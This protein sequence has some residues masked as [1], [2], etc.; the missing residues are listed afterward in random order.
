MGIWSMH[1]L[2]MDS[3]RLGGHLNHQPWAVLLSLLIAVTAATVALRLAQHFGTSGGSQRRWQVVAALALGL[4]VA[5]MHYTAMAG[6]QVQV[7]TAEMSGPRQLAQTQSQA[8]L[9]LGVALVSSLLMLAALWTLF[10]DRRL[11]RQRDATREA[12]IRQQE[13]EARVLERTEEL[14][15]SNAEL[16]RFAYVASHDLQAPL[17]T[18][19]SFAELLDRRYT[20][21]L[22]DR[23]RTYL[24]HIL[25]SG[26]HM[27][28]LID[29]LL[30]YSRLQSERRPMMPVD[31]AQLVPRVIDRLRGDLDAVEADISWGDL[32]TVMGDSLPLEQVFSNLIGNAIKYQRPGTRPQV[33]VWAEPDP[34]GWR[35]GVRDNGI[36][37]DEPYFERIFEVFQRLHSSSEYEGTGIGLALCRKIVEHHGGRLWVDSTPGQG[38]TFW[39]TLS[40]VPVSATMLEPA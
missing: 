33:R 27:K 3:M 37:I 32:P 6:L 39:F 11:A 38:S 12:Q 15:R 5:G 8:T 29:D 9:A 23:G 4:A 35:F 1:Y 31:T 10:M 36:G 18:M 14:R 40:V 34:E 13:L 17:R 30:T 21:Q 26:N 28:H 7:T 2:G 24:Q 25:V 16:E 22:D 20:E 19:V